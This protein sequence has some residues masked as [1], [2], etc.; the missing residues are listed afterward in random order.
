VTDVGKRLR[1]HGM[2]TESRVGLPNGRSHPENTVV[3]DVAQVDDAVDVHE[4]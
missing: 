4:K 3:G 2:S 1:E